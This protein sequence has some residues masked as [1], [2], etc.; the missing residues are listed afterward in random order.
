MFEGLPSAE[1]NPTKS[2]H[3]DEVPVPPLGPNEALVGV[4]A[5]A[6]NFNTV[7]TSIFEPISTFVFLDR[8]AKRGELWKR[9][10]LPY[11]I[12]GSDASRESRPGLS[13][14]RNMVRPLYGGAAG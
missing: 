6:I 1:K 9:H 7:W 10:A 12:V 3:V 13:T 14:Q 2:L 5:S 11:H 4:M 8:N